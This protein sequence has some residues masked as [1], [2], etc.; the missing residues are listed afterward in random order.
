MRHVARGIAREAVKC[1]ARETV[2]EMSHHSFLSLLN[3]L[4]VLL[5]NLYLTLVWIVCCAFLAFPLM[6]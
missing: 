4:T 3:L 5:A 1:I 6:W 2:K